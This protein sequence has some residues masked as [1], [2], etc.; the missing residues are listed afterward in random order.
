MQSPT[1]T[2]ETRT[3]AVIAARLGVP[4]GTVRI[5][6]GN[7]FYETAEGLRCACSVGTPYWHGAAAEAVTQQIIQQAKAR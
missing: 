6:R 5:E 7:V 1:Q 3:L 2:V 4:L